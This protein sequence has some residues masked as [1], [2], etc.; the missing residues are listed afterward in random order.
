MKRNTIVTLALVVALLVIAGFAWPVLS[1]NYAPAAAVS[2]TTTLS[3]APVA[4]PHLSTL[5]DLEGLY[6]DIYTNVNPS[7][8]RIDV[9]TQGGSGQLPQGHPTPSFPFGSQ[10]PSQQAL[11]SGFIWDTKGNIV[12]NNHVVDGATNITVMFSDGTIVDAKVV[13][14]D[15]DSDLAVVNV[16]AAADLLHPVQMADSR[17]VKVGQL[18]VAIGNPFGEQNTMTTGI[19]SALGR[20]LP[21]GGDTQ[22]VGPT[23]SIPDVIQTDAPI[24][25]GNSGGVLLNAQGQVM[26]V[27]SAIESGSGSSSG[28]G[29]A[30][31]SEIVQKVVPALITSGKYVHPYLGISG[32]TLT[33]A[34]S[35]AMGLK[36]EQRGALVA[37]VTNGGPAAKAGLLGSTKN[38]TISGIQTQVGGDVIVAIDNQAIKTFDDIVAYLAR[39]TQ[40]NQTV[41]LTI[42]RDGKEQ[43]VKVTLAARPSSS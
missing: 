10:T 38:V 27:T 30:I 40:V 1:A 29:F 15:P 23:Y 33:P 5:S 31:P 35:K 3:S 8:V 11:G 36:P 28:I 25:P 32:T 42:V 41:T 34:L 16:S 4:A 9:V 13:G 7:V 14:A 19:V 37:T 22:V 12:T 26:G 24:N 2:N 6:E 17:Q 21:A 18:A 43:S 39:A 20:T